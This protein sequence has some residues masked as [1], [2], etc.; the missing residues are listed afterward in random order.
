MPNKNEN[1]IKLSI[2]I[3]TY[4][5]AKYLDKCLKSIYNQKNIDFNEIEV[6]I[7]DNN[8]SDETKFVVDK[9][10]DKFPIFVYKKNSTNIGPTRN[11]RNALNL[12]RGN[13]IWLFGDDDIFAK[14]YAIAKILSVTSTNKYGFIWTGV[15]EIGESDKKNKDEFIEVDHI[16]LLSM[17]DSGLISRCVFQKKAYSLTKKSFLETHLDQ[18]GIIL[19]IAFKN[20]SLIITDPF[21]GY[22]PNNVILPAPRDIPLDYLEILEDF[23]DIYPDSAIKDFKRRMFWELFIFNLAGAKI[24]KQ[25]KYGERFVKYYNYKDFPLI[26][27]A[28]K[29]IWYVV[30]REV[31]LFLKKIY[32][33]IKP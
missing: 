29:L 22:R 7:S 21:V 17:I 26:M 33:S 9:W 11:I 16:K 3:P 25:K 19:E 12:A 18:F 2:A 23:S 1:N 10:K 31:L 5:R 6:V 27:F 24:A 20:K 8:S 14:D 28:Y 13:Y 32:R 30:P 15:K 4:N